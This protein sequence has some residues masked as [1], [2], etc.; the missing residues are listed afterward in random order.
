MPGCQFSPI[1]QRVSGGGLVG[2][3]QA[4][5]RAESAAVTA[6]GGQ[7]LD[8]V[9][10]F[11]TSAICDVVVDNLLVYRDNSHVTVPYA[12]YLTPLIGAKMTATLSKR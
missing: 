5:N 4:G 7:F 12:N 1:G 6:A 10:L 11:C 9:P 8:V 3:D 2:V